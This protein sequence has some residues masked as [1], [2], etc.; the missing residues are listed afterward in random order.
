MFE[1]WGSLE[2]PYCNGQ[3][4]QVKVEQLAGRSEGAYFPLVLIAGDGSQSL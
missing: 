2:V 1:G 4:D 3:E